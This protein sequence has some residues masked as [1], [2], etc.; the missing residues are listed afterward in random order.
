[1][2]ITDNIKEFGFTQAVKYLENN[3]ETNIPKLME[4]VDHFL[5]NSVRPSGRRLKGRI[6]GTSL[7]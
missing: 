5:P 6:I 3:P 4:L 7:L 1:M 2:N